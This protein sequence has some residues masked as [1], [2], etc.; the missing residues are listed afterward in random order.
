MKR[1]GFVP[2]L[3]T[4]ATMMS[5]YAAID[6]W[7]PL[8]TQLEL[9][10]SVYRQMREHLE[11]TPDSIDDPADKS[12]MASFIL[13]PIALYISILGKVG[14]H[15]KA[16]DVFHELD[17]TGPLAP[18]P[19]IYSSL[20]SILADRVDATDVDAQVIAESVSEAKYFWRRHMRSSDK[21]P[22]HDVQPRSIE[23]MIKLLSRGNPSDHELMFD[24]LR[25]MCELPRPSDGPL[26]SPPPSPKK[27]VWLTPWILKEI[28]DGCIAAFRPEMAVHY[29]Q[30]VMDTR[31]LR[32]ILRAWHLSKLIRAHILLANKGSALP[33][34]A[35]NVAEWVEWMVAPRRESKSTVPDERTVLS[36]LELCHRCKDPRSALRI[37][38]AMMVDD[39]KK[40]QKDPSSLSFP[41]KAWEYLF[42]LMTMAGQ[43]ETCRF[44]ELLNLYGS[45]VLDVWGSTSAAIERLQPTEKKAHMSLALEIV[46]V[47]KTAL[48]SSDHQGAEKERPDAADLEAWSDIRKRAESF[49]RKTRQRQKS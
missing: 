14:K 39:A 3:R 33:S 40:S 13:Y 5:G 48:Q 35:E 32:H 36:A 43:D 10:H 7:R 30:S 38:N 6:D 28:L 20:L 47:F 29:A 15:Q 27:K 21:E 8:T 26:P 2:N 17:T 11:R 25:D 9:V 49:L 46:Q 22:Q 45:S 16:F 34:R 41:V 44:F 19:K 23:A 42:R 12:S 31:E 18:H 4:Y 37:A 1:R 24:I